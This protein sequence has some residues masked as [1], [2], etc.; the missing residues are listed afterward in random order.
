MEDLAALI[1]E[2]KTVEGVIVRPLVVRQISPFVRT[3]KKFPPEV[4]DGLQLGRVDPLQ[5]AEHCDVF[6]EAVSVATGKPQE[7][8]GDMRPDQLIN[9]VGAVVEVNIDFFVRSLAPALGNL[10][11]IGKRLVDR[12]GPTSSSGS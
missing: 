4:I 10:V 11:D 1:P 6:V 2:P 8:I 12:L 5:V 9:L 3:L 7:Q